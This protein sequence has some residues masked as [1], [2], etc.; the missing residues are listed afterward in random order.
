MSHRRL[1]VKGKLSFSHPMVRAWLF[2]IIAIA[3]VVITAIY[4]I[5]I[6]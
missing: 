3:V 4:L 5:L 6:P 1:A 2:Q